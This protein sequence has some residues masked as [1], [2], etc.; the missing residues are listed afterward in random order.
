M[1]K[2]IFV[3]RLDRLIRTVSCQPAGDGPTKSRLLAWI[4]SWEKDNVGV[5]KAMLQTR[6][7]I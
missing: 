2:L 5:V 6:T 4:L 1:Y 7:L 3:Q